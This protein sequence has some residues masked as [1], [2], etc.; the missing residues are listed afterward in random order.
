MRAAD[1]LV[2]TDGAFDPLNAASLKAMGDARL[3]GVY[4]DH[5]GVAAHPEFDG[6]WDMSGPIDDAT[7]AS[8]L[9]AMR[10]PRAKR[11]AVA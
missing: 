8:I 4:L 2:I 7:A 1:A 11:K 3:L 10:K 9:N 5:A 6:G